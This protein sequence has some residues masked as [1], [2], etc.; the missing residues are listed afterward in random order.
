[1]KNI[2]IL[3]LYLLS[4]D[5]PTPPDAEH[6]DSGSVIHTE[7]SISVTQI[8]AI[9]TSKKEQMQYKLFETNKLDWL[10]FGKKYVNIRLSDK[11]ISI[12]EQLIDSFVVR[13]YEAKRLSY[14]TFTNYRYQIT[15]AKA[16]DGNRKGLYSGNLPRR[17]K[18]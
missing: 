6:T 13:N 17:D 3:A 2:L 1:M 18:K 16:E 15:P 5:K 10:H 9:D 7:E 12:I 4:C 14:N 8:P 11:E